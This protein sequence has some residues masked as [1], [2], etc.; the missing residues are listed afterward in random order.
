MQVAL[1]HTVM[2]DHRDPSASNTDK[3]GQ[4]SRAQTTCAHDQN[5]GFQ[6][7]LLIRRTLRKKSGLSRI[8]AHCL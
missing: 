8:T 6:K 7:A 3:R 4:N 1:I 5:M 2:I